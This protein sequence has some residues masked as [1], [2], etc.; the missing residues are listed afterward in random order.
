MKLVLTIF[1]SL[2]LF[3]CCSKFKS[4]TPTPVPTVLAAPVL[5]E[6]SLSPATASI[7]AGEEQTYTAQGLDQYQN[8]MTGITDPIPTPEKVVECKSISLQSGGLRES[9]S[10]PAATRDPREPTKIAFH[11]L[12][13]V[14]EYNGNFLRTTT[15]PIRLGDSSPSQFPLHWTR[16]GNRSRSRMHPDGLRRCRTC[17]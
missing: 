9:Q 17:W 11:T 15:V 10:S 7:H 1:T 3:G 5:T 12:N 8:P 2:L 14:D 16:P 13:P 6:I 4:P